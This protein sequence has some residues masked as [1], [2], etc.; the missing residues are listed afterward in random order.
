MGRSLDEAFADR[1][2]A[3]LREKFLDPLREARLER[4]L[5]QNR[6]SPGAASRVPP[7]HAGRLAWRE[8]PSRDDS[9]EGHL[10]Q[11]LRCASRCR[12]PHTLRP[13]TPEA[14]RSRTVPWIT[15]AYA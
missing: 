2:P 15:A 12:L 7:Q 1:L 10:N 6:S 5:E 11:Q 14:C 3:P 4:E 13:F 8:A 9:Y